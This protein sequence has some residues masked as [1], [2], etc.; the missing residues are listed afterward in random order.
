MSE[1]QIFIKESTSPAELS[2]NIP[3]NNHEESELDSPVSP[4]IAKT[5]K[6]IDKMAGPLNL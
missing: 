6:S 5:M 1:N 2:I 3:T 4:N